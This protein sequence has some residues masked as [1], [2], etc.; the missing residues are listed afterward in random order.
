MKKT[1]IAVAAVAAVLASLSARADDCVPQSVLTWVDNREKIAISPTRWQ[2]VRK[3]LLGQD[4][5]MSLD[6]MMVIYNRRVA[7]GW[8]VSHWMPILS[9]VTCLQ[10]E[11]EKASAAIRAAEVDPYADPPEQLRNFDTTIA[12]AIPIK[13]KKRMQVDGEWV[14]GTVDGTDDL[15][16]WNKWGPW[17]QLSAADRKGIHDV[18][19]DGWIQLGTEVHGVGKSHYIGDTPPMGNSYR[20]RGDFVDYVL[21]ENIRDTHSDPQMV[22]EWNARAG[23]WTAYVDYQL[24]NGRYA[25]DTWE[26]IEMRNGMVHDPQAT[27]GP[28]DDGLQAAFFSTVNQPKP[29]LR[30]ASDSYLVGTVHRPKIIGNFVTETGKVFYP[31]Q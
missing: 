9:A 29:W 14:W 3:T 10:A 1:L 28:G 8:G 21:H 24:H 4:G 27:D 13:I 30:K 18:F 25:L 16:A 6:A 15:R 31:S 12:D 23:D 5:G 17:N 20:W 7:N 26:G 19:E 2:N 11:S 22:F